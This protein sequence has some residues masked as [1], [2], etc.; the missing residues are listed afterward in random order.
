MLSD[1]L[2]NNSGRILVIG[3]IMLDEYWNGDVSRISPEAPVPV[4]L[5]DHISYRAGGAANVALNIAGIGNKVDL[6]GVVGEDTSGIKLQEILNSNLNIDNIIITNKKGYPTINKS[7][8]MSSN[9]QLFRMDREK[10]YCEDCFLRLTNEFNKNINNK[11]YDI[12]LLSDYNKG[13]LH[14][15]QLIIKVANEKNIPVLVDPKNPN[16]LLY[17]N[18]TLLTPNIKEFQQMVDLSNEQLNDITYPN[19][20]FL[21]KSHNLIKQLNLKALIV[22]QGKNGLTLLTDN[23]NDQHFASYSREVFD[24]TGAG[25]TV[26]ATIA[27]CLANG[28]DLH[29]ASYLATIAAGIVV[30]KLG[31]CPVSIEDIHQ[32]ME[33]I[34]KKSV[35]QNNLN[36]GIIEPAKLAPIIKNKQLMGDKVVF[37]NGCFD[38]LHA[39]HIHYLEKA[40]SLGDWLVVAVNDDQS[41]REL[42]G[43]DRP[44]NNLQDRME[45]LAGIKS[46]DWVVSFGCGDIRPGKLIQELNPNILV[47]SKEAFASIEEIPDYEGADY[48]LQQ[49]GEV[50]L[51]E[52]PLVP[53]C[54]T[55]STKVINKIKNLTTI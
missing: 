11:I 41:I 46:V 4:I 6:M 14:D 23:Y 52:R 10:R 12:V 55:S 26:I 43:S 53:S 17:K 39:G 34:E 44:V 35:K 22:T 45:V 30:S 51:L 20:V 2:N 8:I 54:S 3:D 38:I 47:K 16:Y 27:A 31:T 33:N 9:Q 49:G 1:L 19:Q 37:V 28:M 21:E 5:I 25:D 18:A 24:V 50:Y 32:E 13:T 7:R 29:N 48:V 36:L 40:K 42:K 15:P